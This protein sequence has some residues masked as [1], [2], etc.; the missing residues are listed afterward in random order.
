MIA[1]D[2]FLPSETG[3][4]TPPSKNKQRHFNI[5]MSPLYLVKLNI[6]Q[7]WPTAYCSAFCWTDCSKLSF[8]IR[9]FRCLLE[10][11]FSSLPTENV[12]LSH[13]FYHKFIFKLNMVNFSIK[14]KLN[15]HDLR[16][17]TVM[18]TPQLHV[19]YLLNCLITS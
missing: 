19:I 18:N 11:P 6:A 8:N 9:F 12:L 1:F 17:V 13:G 14:P 15:C 2:Y 10:N 7:K 16:R 3:I 4:K 5:T